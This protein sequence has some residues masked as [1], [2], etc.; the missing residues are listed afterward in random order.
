L[1]SYRICDLLE[2]W[3][4]D[5][6]TDFATPGTSGAI[7][8]LLKQIS[9]HLYT[10]HYGSD[11]LPFLDEIPHLQDVDASWSFYEDAGEDSDEEG[12]E[13]LE[14]EEEVGLRVAARPETA[15]ST[16]SPTVSNPE[17]KSKL[18]TRERKGSLPLSTRSSAMP[19]SI[20]LSGSSDP[21]RI[22]AM[23][24]RNSPRELVRL[25]QTLATYDALDIA[26]QITKMQSEMFLAIEV[27][28]SRVS[29]VPI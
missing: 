25:A 28:I 20:T 18:S 6:P 12:I 2:G 24:K 21:S 3:I 16:A 1:L 19:L 11:I 7:T 26:Q 13:L 22:A 14:D 29:P 9:S 23:P 17:T 10:L 15:S 5:Y 27:C 8:A 4:K